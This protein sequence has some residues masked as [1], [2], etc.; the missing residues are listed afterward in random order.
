MVKHIT[1]L[2]IA[3]AK[4][5]HCA[6]QDGRWR[7]QVAPHAVPGELRGAA[8]MVSPCLIG[9]TVQPFYYPLVN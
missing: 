2:N 1:F 5:F 3:L 8:E 7:H 6:R 9:T 4:T